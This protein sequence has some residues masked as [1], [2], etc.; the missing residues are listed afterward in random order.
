ML[1]PSISIS[2]DIWKVSYINNLASVLT[3]NHFE[4]FYQNSFSFFVT[5]QFQHRPNCSSTF[6]FKKQ[7]HLTNFSSH[8]PG[9]THVTLKFCL[10]NELFSVPVADLK[11]TSISE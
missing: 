7:S 8:P 11:T 2:S 4:F 10:K 9:T 5:I 1:S 3:K 6:A